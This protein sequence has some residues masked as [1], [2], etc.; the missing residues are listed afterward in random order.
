V[1]ET[2]SHREDDVALR[3]DCVNFE[4]PTAVRDPA[5]THES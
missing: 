4:D 1:K 3:E 5:F 2:D